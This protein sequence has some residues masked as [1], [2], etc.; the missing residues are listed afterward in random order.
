MSVATTHRTHQRTGP[1][2]AALFSGSFIM[3]MAELLVVGVL[4]L[5]ATNLDVPLSST[6]VLVT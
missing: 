4:H 6:G 3:G 5:I 1:A 2:L